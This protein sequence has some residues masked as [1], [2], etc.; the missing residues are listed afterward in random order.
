[1]AITVAQLT[2][3]MAVVETGSVTAAAD[4][5]VVTQPTVSSSVAALGRALGC[6]LLERS[7]RGVRLSEAG[8]AFAPYAEDVLGL[9]R[10]GARAAREGA[11]LRARSIRI[12]AVT[13]AAESF[14]PPLMHA[15]CRLHPEIDLTLDV[16]NR[17]WVFD[18]VASHEADLAISGRPPDRK[19]LH[20]RPL[21]DNEVACITAPDD[22]LAHRGALAS[23]ELGDRPWLLREPGSGTRAFGEQFLCD[24]GIEPRTLTLGSNGAIK[25]AARAGLGVSLLSRAAVHSELASG[26]LSE[27]AL[28]D[29]PEPRRWYVVHSAVGPTRSCVTEL[30]EFI[31]AECA[32][33]LERS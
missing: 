31:A 4:R 18:R 14:V 24:R 23:G 32:V 30:I 33:A 11:E 22:A 9:L 29:G 12:A 5:L 13:T 19:R 10:S 8:L 15:W 17:D 27:I 6:D 26:R 16:G 1:M 28:S 2:A 20:G 3:F 25:Q 21:M 7:G